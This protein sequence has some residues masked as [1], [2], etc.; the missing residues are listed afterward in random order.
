MTEEVLIVY[1]NNVDKD[2]EFFID[3]Y[4]HINGQNPINYFIGHHETLSEKESQLIECPYIYINKS[5]YQTLID[6]RKMN[7]GKHII[8]LKNA[9]L[10]RSMIKKFLSYERPLLYG[11]DPKQINENQQYNF[12]NVEY[13]VSQC[14]K[15]A[16]FDQLIDYKI[17]DPQKMFKQICD[18][19]ANGKDN[20]TKDTIINIVYEMHISTTYNSIPS[21]QSYSNFSV[22]FDDIIWLPG[23][24][25]SDAFLKWCQI[26][27]DSITFN[28][29]LENIKIPVLKLAK[30]V[31]P[32]GEPIDVQTFCI[33]Y[34]TMFYTLISSFAYYESNLSDKTIEMI[35]REGKKANAQL[36]RQMMENDPNQFIKTVSKEQIN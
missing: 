24:E 17:I 19:F 18:F 21:L 16:G 22:M 7:D 1:Y 27:H 5:L 35:V 15:I 12:N 28:N 8:L 2:S 10:N 6:I 20:Y 14:K 11:L 36:F 31:T 9:T 4:K 33:S 30:G 26:I 25:T 13:H 32:T 29:K 23:N 3:L 34:K